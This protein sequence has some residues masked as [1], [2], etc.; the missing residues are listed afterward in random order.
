MPMSSH[1]DFSRLNALINDSLRRY[2][3]EMDSVLLLTKEKEKNLLIL[4]SQVSREIKAWTS[5]QHHCN[6]SEVVFLTVESQYIQHL[7][8]NVLV[9][10]SNFLVKSGSKWEEF[11]HLLWASL[12]AAIL[13]IHSFSSVSLPD[14]S[15]I[16][17]DERSSCH[18]SHTT[19]KAT[20]TANSDCGTAS[21]ISILRPKLSNANW[22]TAT[23]LLRVL[24]NI[25]KSLKQDHGE[26]LGA[27]LHSFS[28]FPSVPWDLLHEIYVGQSGGQWA[29]SKD[30]L[31]H[32]NICSPRSK[33]VFLGTLLQLCCSMADR[34]LLE[35]IVG[36][37]FDE[38]AFLAKITN[39]VPKFL[40]WCFSEHVDYEGNCISRYLRH[41]MLMLMIRLGFHIHQ[42]HSTLVLWLQL[43]QKYFEDLLYQPISDHH[44]HEDYLEGSPFRSSMAG[45]EKTY[46]LSDRHLQ[47]QAI[48]LHFKCSLSLFSLNEETGGKCTCTTANSTLTCGL[49]T[50]R[51]H[52]CIKGLSEISEW[53]LR[54][55]APE[56]FVDHSTYS[57][58]CGSFALSFLRLYMDEDDFLFEMLLQLLHSPFTAELL[59]Y[60]E[61]N[62]IFEEVKGNTHFHI[63]S[64]FNPIHLFH[65]FLAELHYD[66]LV[67]LD[68]LISKDTGVH[69]VQYLLSS[70][71][72]TRAGDWL[73]RC[74]Q[75][76]FLTLRT[77]YLGKLSTQNT[78]WCLRI[79]CK[80]WHVFVEF[81]VTGNE[82]SEI[83][84]KKRKVCMDEQGS[85]GKA[86]LSSLSMQG[87]GS[88]K[89]F[90]RRNKTKQ[91]SGSMLETF[92]QHAFENA[93]ECLLCLKES[94]ENLHQ[95]HLF[96]YNPTVLLKSFA[97]FQ[98][99]CQLQEK[100]HL[101]KNDVAA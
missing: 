65:L 84:S 54:H 21:V 23:G 99:L 26:L 44:G 36:G 17:P 52:S 1:S 48:F 85:H 31:P 69:C 76:E 28:S 56:S 19:D 20:G 72:F 12:E 57:K 77:A 95:K 2:Y 81:L 8:G 33:D 83:S 10:I 38:L 78:L 15:I 45:G 51:E 53:L 42:Q 50:S 3:T 79:V 73:E 40:C 86:E 9:A 39:L 34:T 87:I 6:S 67:L 91:K 68:Y 11:L 89:A 93:K 7:A 35:E 13:N 4:L 41:K 58:V 100:Q 88:S 16:L 80:S 97:R 14:R 64:V 60:K 25:L 24:R 66:H 55:L 74:Y 90:E 96:P 62:K 29:N 82:V 59:S 71:S 18:Y 43:L 98:E 46:N 49:Q 27:Y 61:N 75:V 92:R 22:V 5:E 30:T 63:S 94:V 70:T 47:R 101:Q 37:S 32:G